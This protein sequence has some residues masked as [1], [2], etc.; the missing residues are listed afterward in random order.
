MKKDKI[1]YL[2][3]RE[4]REAR[5]RRKEGSAGKAMAITFIGMLILAILLIILENYGIL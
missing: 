1:R 4:T 5:W 2:D 3:N